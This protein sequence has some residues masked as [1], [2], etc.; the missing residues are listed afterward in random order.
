MEQNTKQ[1]FLV[2]ALIGGIVGAAAALI[3]TPVSGAKLRN[4][5]NSGFGYLEQPKKRKKAVKK[6][7]AKATGHASNN[8]THAPKAKK[9]RKKKASTSATA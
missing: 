2:G 7:L 1:E 6:A 3:F 5:I 4:E 9:P 8:S